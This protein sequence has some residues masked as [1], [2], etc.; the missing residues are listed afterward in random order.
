M[1]ALPEEE[2][3]KRQVIPVSEE[4]VQEKE[5]AVEEIKEPQSTVVS[6]KEEKQTEPV[7]DIEKLMRQMTK[8]LWEER[9]SCGRRLR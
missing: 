3:E 7:V 6:K 4:K 5:L 1:Q 9:E 8:K 2:T